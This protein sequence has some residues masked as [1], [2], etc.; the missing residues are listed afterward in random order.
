MRQCGIAGYLGEHQIQDLA[1]N[2]VEEYI[3]IL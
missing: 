2:V 3:H 1:A